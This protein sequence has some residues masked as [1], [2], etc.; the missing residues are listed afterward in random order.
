MVFQ[1]LALFPHMTVADNI[2]FPLMIKGMA[3]R[4]VAARVNG[5][6]RTVRVEHLL[7]QRPG[8]LSGVRPSGWPWP[9]RSS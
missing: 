2:G 3:A 8:T 1:S 9:A 6:A 4:E 7:G 5:V